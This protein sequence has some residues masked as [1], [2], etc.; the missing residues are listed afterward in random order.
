MSSCDLF[1]TFGAVVKSFGLA[2]LALPIWHIIFSQPRQ[3][4]YAFAPRSNP[5]AV[6]C[7]GRAIL[8]LTSIIGCWFRKPKTSPT[9]H[10]AHEIG[11]SKTSWRGRFAPAHLRF[12]LVHREIKRRQHP[13]GRQLPI[14]DVRNGST[15]DKPVTRIIRRNSPDVL[16]SSTNWLIAGHQSFRPFATA[17]ASTFSP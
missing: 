13:N 1:A 11:T 9:S 2:F 14:H 4:N 3:G 6:G 15:P 8:L 10:A 7:R 12:R 5:R 16:A 17:R